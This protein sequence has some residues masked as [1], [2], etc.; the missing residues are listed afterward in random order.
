MARWTR[1]S[2]Q[3]FRTSRKPLP[4]VHHPQELLSFIPMNVFADFTEAAWP[5]TIAVVIFSAIVG[6]MKLRDKDP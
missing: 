4:Q 5:S 6:V 3:P 1:P 2:L